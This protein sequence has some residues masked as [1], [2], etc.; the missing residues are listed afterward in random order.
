M[1]PCCGEISKLMDNSAVE[2][3]K[4]DTGLEVVLTLPFMPEAAAATDK[5]EKSETI[6]SLFDPL[7][8]KILDQ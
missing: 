3:L 1:C 5:G 7:V 4:S 8:K 6:L 2:Q